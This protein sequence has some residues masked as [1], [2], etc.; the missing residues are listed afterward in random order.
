MSLPVYVMQSMLLPIEICKEVDAKVRGFVWGSTLERLKVHLLA[1]EVIAQPKCDGG[2][3]LQ[4]LKVSNQALLAKLGW[5]LL[6][7]PNSLWYRVLHDK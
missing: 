5:R 1:W 2:L 6:Q 4:S 3:G 7:E